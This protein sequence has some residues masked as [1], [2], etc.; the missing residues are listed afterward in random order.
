VSVIDTATHAAALPLR[1]PQSA[2]RRREKMKLSLDVVRRCANEQ[3]NKRAL[4]ER[5]R[6]IVRQAS[7]EGKGDLQE[8][9]VVAERPRRNQTESTTDYAFMTSN[10]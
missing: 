7:Q 10:R 3:P 9:A 4:A 2:M 6:E 1:Y 5:T 8:R